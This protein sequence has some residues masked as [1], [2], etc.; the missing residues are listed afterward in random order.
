MPGKLT[1]AVVPAPPAPTY[2]QAWQEALYGPRGFYRRGRGP[3]ADFRTPVTAGTR[4]AVALGGRAARLDEALGRPGG[5]SVVDVGAGDGRLLGAL[6]A[7]APARWRLVGV[8]VRAR[9]TGL[10]ARVDWRPGPPRRVVG[11]VIAVEYLDV[12][13]CEV[14]RHGRVVLADGSPGP[15]PEAADR[16][17]LDTWWPGWEDG[18]AEVGRSRDAA[19]EDLAGRVRAGVALAVDYGHLRS[20]RVATLTGYRAGRPCPPTTDGSADLTA[21]V[22]LDSLGATLDRQR[23]CLRGLGLRAQPPGPGTAGRGLRAG[24]ARAAE[25]AEL[26]AVGGFGDFAW[27][28]A[29]A[30]GPT[31]AELTG[32]PPRPAPTPEPS[33]IHVPDD[34]EH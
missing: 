13:P 8:E 25:E 32:R 34:E 20:A 2:R 4:F 11:L 28:S 17:W 26:V 14:V 21:H 22:A 24:L 12:M 31:V 9:P 23:D 19:W 18:C 10:P 6:A 27:I 33:P 3:G 5:F 1:L 15:A 7:T 29:A 16:R 30:D